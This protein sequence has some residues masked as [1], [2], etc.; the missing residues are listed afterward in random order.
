MKLLFKKY[1]TYGKICL[2]VII[3]GIIFSKI[4]AQAVVKM[5][6]Q[7]TLFTFILLILITILKFF[8]QAY[9]WSCCLKINCNHQFSLKSILKTHLVGLALRFFLPGGYGTFG[10]AFYLDQDKKQTIISI[11][12]EKFFGV[13]V[14]I[15]FALWSFLFTISRYLFLIRFLA[16]FVSILPFL[17]PLIFAKI[18]TFSQRTAYYK[19]LIKII[20][21]QIIYELLT[22]YQYYI[23]FQ[24]ILGNLISFGKIA[25][26]ISFVLVANTIPITYSGLGIRETV[27][28][29]ILPKVG[30]PAE[31]AVGASLLIFFLNSIVPA[32]PGVMMIW[33][34]ALNKK[35]EQGSK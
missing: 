2:S 31:A 4:E 9:L 10:K 25:Q 24:A 32:L 16:I 3:L 23:L 20:I 27:S 26:T 19:V 7:L 15:F 8:S 22:F 34:K 11:F 35:K 12:L 29:Y 13:W 30:I 6:Y 33:G 17:L 5:V 21:T 28:M 14:I 1:Q 18:S